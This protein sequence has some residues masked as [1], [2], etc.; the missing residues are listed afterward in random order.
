MEPTTLSDDAMS[1]SG[2]VAMPSEIRLAKDRRTISILWADGHEALFDS[3]TLRAKCQSAPS[4]SK[5][6]LNGEPSAAEFEGL[7][8]T[9]LRPI[10]QYAINIVFSDGHDRGIYP[11]PFLKELSATKA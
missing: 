10:G 3:A 1:D 4:K 6:I 2:H 7:T 5:A 9:D 8:I 11:W